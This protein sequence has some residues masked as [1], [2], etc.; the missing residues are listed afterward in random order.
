MRSPAMV[1]YYRLLLRLIWVLSQI[2]SKKPYKKK[3]KQICY[4]LKLQKTLSISKQLKKTIQK[5][6]TMMMTAAVAVKQK[7]KIRIRIKTRTKI[8][9]VLLRLALHQTLHQAQPKRVD[10]LKTTMR[11]VRIH[12]IY[13]PARNLYK[14][15]LEWV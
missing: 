5:I 14:H 15:F 11:S 4:L 3:K 6:M 12:R 2:Y 1:A 7:T 13:F 10:L 8:K 9:A